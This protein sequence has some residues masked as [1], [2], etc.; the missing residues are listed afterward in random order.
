MHKLYTNYDMYYKPL[1]NLEIAAGD[2]G[3]PYH[4]Q[5]VMLIFTPL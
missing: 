2:H 3:H 5:V 1:L 4:E